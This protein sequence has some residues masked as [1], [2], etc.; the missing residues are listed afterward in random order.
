MQKVYGKKDE[1]LQK[2]WDAKV[3][4]KSFSRNERLE[5]LEALD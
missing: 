1:R 2:L 4:A 5:K 3:T